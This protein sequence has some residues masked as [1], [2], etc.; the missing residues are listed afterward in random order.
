ICNNEE[1]FQIFFSTEHSSSGP[2][3]REC[4]SFEGFCHVL[5]F[6]EELVAKVPSVGSALYERGTA[7]TAE[8]EKLISLCNKGGNLA[9]ENAEACEA[10]VLYQLQTLLQNTMNGHLLRNEM[11][12]YQ[13]ERLNEEQSRSELTPYFAKLWERLTKHILLLQN[14]HILIRQDVKD[15]FGALLI[16]ENH[17]QEKPVSMLPNFLRVWP[18]TNEVFGF[19]LSGLNI[20]GLKE[21]KSNGT[22]S[23]PSFSSL[24]RKSS[25][26][27][28]ENERG[29]ISTI[30][31][32]AFWGESDDSNSDI[33]EALRPQE[34][35]SQ[36]DGFSDF[37]D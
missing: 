19:Y 15:M 22:S 20:N 36:E 10:L 5:T 11:L 31:S 12:N 35:C 32:K 13:R 33:E 2:E 28:D 14:Y 27:R 29:I 4:L 9:Q 21:E 18:T 16:L 25:L 37:Y 7:N 6:I 34:H 24:E 23:E 8:R 1:Y 17:E 30:K 26:S 3:L